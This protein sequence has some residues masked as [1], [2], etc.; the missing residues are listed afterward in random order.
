VSLISTLVAAVKGDSG[1]NGAKQVVVVVLMSVF[2]LKSAFQ[3][4][5]T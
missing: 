3:S 4:P 2:L 1:D 5:Y